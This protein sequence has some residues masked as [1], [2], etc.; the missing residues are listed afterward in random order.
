MVVLRPLEEVFAFV[1]DFDNWTR[2][3]PAPRE[4]QFPHGPV[5]VGATFRQVFEFQGQRIELLCEAIEYE[6]NEKLSYECVRDD[7]SFEIGFVFEPVEGGTR[8][9][10][11]GQGSA[12]G[13][14]KLFEP[15]VARE[16][17]REI[18]ANLD[19]LKSLLESQNL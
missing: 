9:T 3:E 7:S 12:N 11:K 4:D 15:L 16:V 5:K 1:A 18:E 13:P 17:N 8:L 6:P 14:L 10:G 2:R 19:K